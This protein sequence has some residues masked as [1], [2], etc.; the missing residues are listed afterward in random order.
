MRIS[1]TLY[2]VPKPSTYVLTPPKPGA[3]REV[4]RDNIVQS[5]LGCRKGFHPYMEFRDSL[6]NL[7]QECICP[8]TEY[9]NSDICICEKRYI[10]FATINS[11]RQLHNELLTKLHLLQLSP[12][13]TF[14]LTK[15]NELFCRHILA[16]KS[17]SRTPDSSSGR[18]PVGHQWNK[19][20]YSHYAQCSCRRNIILHQHLPVAN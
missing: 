17:D 5:K 10:S 16:I 4:A 18:K 12:F 6:Q 9:I 2:I 20:Y 14:T 7:G 11:L 3:L 15:L 8:Q 1:W 19:S 13:T